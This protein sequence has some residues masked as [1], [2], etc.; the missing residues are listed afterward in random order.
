M[1]IRKTQL[2]SNIIESSRMKRILKTLR[3]FC[4]IVDNCYQQERDIQKQ[5]HRFF[6]DEEIKGEEKPNSS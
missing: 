3:F 6:Q 5:M 2:G 1:E 4:F